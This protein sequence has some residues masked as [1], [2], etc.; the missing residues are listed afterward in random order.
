[1]KR[2]IDIPQDVDGKILALQE[3]WKRFDPER[4]S[5][6]EVVRNLLVLGLDAMNR[7]GNLPG[8][9]RDG[10]VQ[11]RYTVNASEAARRI[12]IAKPAVYILAK[13]ADFP[14][15]SIENRILICEPQLGEWV[16]EQGKNHT[17]IPL[18]AAKAQ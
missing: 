17:H 12:G 13:R 9:V 3:S 1:M 6:A 8:A 16:Q 4:S 14:A 11:I 7:A 15:F 18:C 10:K 2:D 5:Y